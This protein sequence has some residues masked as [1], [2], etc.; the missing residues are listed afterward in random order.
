MGFDDVLKRRRVQ[1]IKH[2]AE[3]RPLWNSKAQIMIIITGH[4]RSQ[5]KTFLC[6][7]LNIVLQ[8]FSLNIRAKCLYYHVVRERRGVLNCCVLVAIESQFCVLIMITALF[9]N[10]R[11]PKFNS[12]LHNCAFGCRQHNYDHKQRS[13]AERHKEDRNPPITNHKLLFPQSSAKMIDGSEVRKRQL[14]FELQNLRFFQKCQ[15]GVWK[16]RG[17]KKLEF[18]LKHVSVLSLIVK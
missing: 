8:R 10:T 18:C 14:A 16:N 4:L 3:D 7:A 1:Q 2:R 17:L 11:T 15:G 5:A 9:K 13:Y 6:N 12:C